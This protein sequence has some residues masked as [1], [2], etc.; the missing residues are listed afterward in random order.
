M[1]GTNAIELDASSTFMEHVRPTQPG[2]ASVWPH[3]HSVGSFQDAEGSFQDAEGSFQDAEGSFQDAEG[4]FQDAEGSFQDAEGS[5]ETLKAPTPM[6][7]YQHI[8][9]PA[10]TQCGVAATSKKRILEKAAD[11]IAS[12]H[13]NIDSRLLFDQLM[14]RERLGSTGLGDGVAIPHCRLEGFSDVR[15][16]FFSFEQGIDF[17]ASDGKPVDL[18]FV[19]VVPGEAEDTHLVVLSH[20]AQIFGNPQ[21]RSDLRAHSDDGALF[22]AILTQLQSA[23]EAAG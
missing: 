13:P 10:C 21:A 19:L 18:M 20:L 4:S 15:A 22:D 5:F 8:L 14:A 1:G 12:S 3:D 16:A 9:S 17:D 6:I 11:L 2:S 7:D 23:S